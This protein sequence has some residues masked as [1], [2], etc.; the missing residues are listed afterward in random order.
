[1]DVATAEEPV[2]APPD[3]PKPAES[4]AQAGLVVLGAEDADVCA[5]DGSCW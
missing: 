1:M 2:S 5:D 4:V 3:E